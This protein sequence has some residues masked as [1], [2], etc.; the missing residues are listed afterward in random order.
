MID[1]SPPAP[2]G[3]EEL[4]AQLTGRVLLPGDA[5]HELEVS[6]YN[7]AFTPAPD[8]VV[9][10]AGTPDVQAA[11]RHAA[12]HGLAVGV[13]ATGH[14]AAHSVDGGLMISTR[15][16]DG[17]TIDP[18][19]RT[20][21]VQAGATWRDVLREAA[22]HE[23]APLSGSSSRVGAVGYTLG[24][25]IPLMGR[26]FGFAADRVHSFEVVT[27]DARALHVDA[28]HEPEL[29]WALRGGGGSFAVVCEMTIDVVPVATIYGGGV[30]YPA[31]HTAAV[32][33]AYRMWAE[34]LPEETN[35]S[36]ALI[37]L[38]PD[39]GGGTLVHLRFCHV[40]SAEDGARLLEPMRVTAPVVMDDVR[41]MPYTE[42]DTIHRDPVD[43][44]PYYSRGVLLDE[45]TEQTLEALLAALGP[46]SAVP[47]LF[48]ELR[49]MDGAY[50]RLPEVPNCTGG[51]EAAYL[52]SVVAPG[53]PELRQVAE[54]GLAG[55]FAALGQWCRSGTA[56][57]VH[58]AVGDEADRARA[59]EP[60]TYD[61]LVR[62]KHEVDPHRLLRVG[63]IIG[64]ESKS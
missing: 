28:D 13:Q 50:R 34:T 33:R 55:A 40:G 22:A 61:R 38:P 62:L 10:A 58:G 36:I 7:T 2:P 20:A 8:L 52:L 19:A 23:L 54:A 57:N 21:T 63:H 47:A 42:A 44:L 12:R 59:W 4:G 56:V 41:L 35:S 30:F 46:D 25:G 51:R 9:R 39:Q 18:V 5:G 3:T 32:F 24:G 15:A 48:W 26:T 11:M 31:T 16:M 49:P 64:L 1:G 53:A 45:F 14:G 6:T 17:V 29:F 60:A 37:N 43:P 27:P